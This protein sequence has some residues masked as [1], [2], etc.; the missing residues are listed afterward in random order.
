MKSSQLLKRVSG[1]HNRW[2][3]SREN[4]QLTASGHILTLRLTWLLSQ[5]KEFAPALP[6]KPTLL[7]HKT[8]TGN[9][10]RFPNNWLNFFSPCLR[11]ALHYHKWMKLHCKL[12]SLYEKSAILQVN[13]IVNVA[14]RCVNPFNPMRKVTYSMFMAVS[15]LAASMVYSWSQWR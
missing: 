7:T 9:C 6:G 4:W 15:T 3:R 10:Q 2:S 1:R 14:R 11:F 5:I 8:P 12:L 13:P